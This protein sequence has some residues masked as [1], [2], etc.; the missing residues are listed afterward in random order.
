MRAE[1]IHAALIGVA[2][3]IFLSVA[4]ARAGEADTTDPAQAVA[5]GGGLATPPAVSD[6]L[7]VSG[8]A[9]AGP[10]AATGAGLPSQA[11]PDLVARAWHAPA[12]TLEQRIATTRRTGLEV[13]IWSLDAAARALFRGAR[14]E[15]PLERL[16]GAVSLAPD[17][18][19]AHFALARELWLHEDEPMEAVHAAVA[20]LQA[21]GR[22]P[23]ASLWFAGSGL[24]VLAAALVGGGLLVI[25]LAGLLSAAHAGH[26]LG[27]L[28]PGAPPAYARLAVLGAVLLVPVAL[29]EG[30]LGLTVVLLAVACLY[31]SRSRRLALALAA[32]AVF[33]GL[34]P[35]PRAAGALLEAFPSDPV[36][37]AASSV[38]HGAASP[39]DLARLQASADSDL[40]ALR[41]LALHAR[42]SGNLGRADALY[43][44]LLA[45]AP[46]DVAVLNNAANVRLALGHM[47]SALELYGRALDR[48]SSAIV[49]F[50]MSQAY[51]RSFQVDQ[52]NRALADAQRVD[53]DLLADLTTLQ[54]DKT[55]GFVVDMPLST[56]ALWRR[57]WEAQRGADVATE[58]RAPLAPGHLGSTSR[59]GGGALAVAWVLG[60][61]GAR[62]FRSSRSCVRCGGR[63]CRRCG[64]TTTKAQCESCTRLFF[65][66]ER[67][68]RALRVKRIEALQRRERRMQRL[69]MVASVL[70]P[71]AA[72]LL[73]DRPV[74][75]LIATVCFALAL[76][77]IF[78]RRGVVPDP[79]VAGVGGPL[80]FL[81]VAGI[82]SLL[83]VAA[84]VT[85]LTE[86]S[87][88]S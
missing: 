35:L 14:T 3:G 78:W 60:W 77:A 37:R 29:G 52:L 16:R 50:N 43:Q 80:T 30:W 12:P 59:N 72:G 63:I 47:N 39:V 68:D 57:A 28:V 55:E 21:I 15:P 23:E 67:T 38:G 81:A 83:Y 24:L 26:D 17:L 65:H 40:L 66:P 27:H 76:G 85:S 20:G 88:S 71:G 64:E 2:L 70:V 31:G 46:T 82:A 8:P 87:E 79:F 4:A 33:A 5:A 6:S 73:H 74:R 44:Q 32:L 54:R 84:V 9:P 49:L 56:R 13:G 69:T 53:P 22:H 1:R 45:Q 25:W 18:P 75:A 51:G 58:L 61:L 42:Q 62:S 11:A 34:Y 19:A 10:A 41:G 7:P 36:A 86:E 48:Q